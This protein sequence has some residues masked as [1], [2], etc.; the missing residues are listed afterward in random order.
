MNFGINDDTKIPKYW[1]YDMKSLR[2]S[3]LCFMKCVLISMTLAGCEQH[4]AKDYVALK[5]PAG[6]E[7]LSSMDAHFFNQISDTNDAAFYVLKQKLISIINALNENNTA[8]PEEANCKNYLVKIRTS[9]GTPYFAPN[10]KFIRER[11]GKYLSQA[12]N[13]WLAHLD[14]SENIVEDAALMTTPDKLREYIIY[15]EDFVEKN[16]NFVD[17]TEVEKRLE[18]YVNWYLHGL[19]NSPVYDYSSG[20]MK[21]DYRLSYEKFLSENT[22]SKYYPQVKKM[23]DRAKADAFRTHRNNHL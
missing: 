1:V 5:S 8:T 7:Q 23:Y 17:L 20:I 10:W 16:Q 4:S 9:E 11:Y 22:E 14:A 6:L 19:D 15:L 18:L 13:D 21:S 3:A 2:G 12:Y